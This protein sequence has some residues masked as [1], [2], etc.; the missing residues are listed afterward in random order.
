MATLYAAISSGEPH[1]RRRSLIGSPL[2]ALAA[3]PSASAFASALPAVLPVSLPDPLCALFAFVLPLSD[4]VQPDRIVTTASSSTKN[5]EIDFRLL[6]D[7]TIRAPFCVHP[8]W[9]IAAVYDGFIVRDGQR[10][11][12]PSISRMVDY[13]WVLCGRRIMTLVPS[14]GA[15][16]IWMPYASRRPFG[17]ARSCS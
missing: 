12:N 5:R 8:H 13:Y 6:S 4:F 17:C 1:A 2:P 11:Q 9:L 16:S 15:E 14:P 7:H 3:P 10:F